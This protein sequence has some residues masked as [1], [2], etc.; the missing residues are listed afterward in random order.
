MAV[1]EIAV[2]RTFIRNRIRMI[3]TTAAASRSTRF[4]LS[5]EVSMK[6]ACRN[7]TLVAETPWRQRLLDLR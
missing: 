1:S 5:T 2:A 3:A 4:T 7:C 6:V